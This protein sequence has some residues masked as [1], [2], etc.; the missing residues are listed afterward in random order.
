[1]KATFFERLGAYFIDAII[2]S[3]I[4]SLI[5][6]GVGENTASEEL[7]LEELDTKLTSG[8]ITSAAY[9]EEYSNILYEVQK[10]NVIIEN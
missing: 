10:H 9:L 8:E 6:F 3:L 2:V 1:M 5:C 4:F 7:L